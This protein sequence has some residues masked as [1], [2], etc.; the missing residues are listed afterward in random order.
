MAV[1]KKALDEAN[2]LSLTFLEDL[3]NR[4]SYHAP[5]PKAVD[6]H[7]TIRKSCYDLALII[8]T[9]VPDC[10]ERSLAITKLEEVMMWANAGI[11]RHH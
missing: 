1:S 9:Q 5:D 7:V 11:A 3:N 6:A 8:T 10:R 4:F 2:E